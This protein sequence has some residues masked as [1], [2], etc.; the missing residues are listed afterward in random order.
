MWPEASGSVCLRINSVI[1]QVAHVCLRT[2]GF[3]KIV[4]S[5]GQCST[6][7]LTGAII[8]A[9]I[10]TAAAT[11]AVC[12]VLL[13]L[14]VSHTRLHRLALSET[15]SQPQPEGAPAP[16]AQQEQKLPAEDGIG[17]WLGIWLAASVQLPSC[18][19]EYLPWQ[20][21]RLRC[22]SSASFI[23]SLQ[24]QAYT[25]ILIGKCSN[26]SLRALHDLLMLAWLS[27]SCHF[28]IY[29]VNWHCHCH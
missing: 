9:A 20:V 8:I 6:V 19:P 27:I 11:G 29:I 14:L 3:S 22:A 4:S 16:T 1:R 26:M 13:L 5:Q 10:I 18:F 23:C 21:P 24:Q 12:V 17:G 25:I 7:P 2:R 28:V 15:T